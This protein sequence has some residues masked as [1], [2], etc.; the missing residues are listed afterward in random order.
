[1]EGPTPMERLRILRVVVI[2]SS[3]PCSLLGSSAALL[4]FS[5]AW[6]VARIGRV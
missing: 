1:M 3:F 4:L 5:S 2:S 6:R